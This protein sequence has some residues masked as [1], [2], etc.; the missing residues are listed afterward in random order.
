MKS[1]GLSTVSLFHSLGGPFNLFCEQ[2]AKEGVT[3][4]QKCLAQSLPTAF[5]LLIRKEGREIW[6]DQE[7]KQWR[8]RERWSLSSFSKKKFQGRE[9]LMNVTLRNNLGEY[10]FLTI[11]MGQGEKRRW[12]KA[13]C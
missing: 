13:G 6:T 7:S 4:L 3:H 12:Y 8:A 5:C 9:K 10:V 2:S 1:R 11:L